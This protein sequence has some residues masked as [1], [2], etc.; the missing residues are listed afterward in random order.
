MCLGSILEPLFAIITGKTPA[1][2]VDSESSSLLAT[3]GQQPGYSAPISRTHLTVESQGNNPFE[4]SPTAGP[5]NGQPSIDQLRPFLVLTSL[6]DPTVNLHQRDPVTAMF[7]SPDRTTE[8][9]ELVANIGSY[10]LSFYRSST[11]SAHAFEVAFMII[12]K[13]VDFESLLPKAFTKA[14]ATVQIIVL[15]GKK[16]TD[17][18]T[19]CPQAVPANFCNGETPSLTHLLLR[20]CLLHPLS[21]L[22]RTVTHLRVEHG[23]DSP[24]AQTFIYTISSGANLR[25]LELFEAIPRGISKTV[26][27]IRLPRLQSLLIATKGGKADIESFKHFF[28]ILTAPR[29]IP[30]KV[31]CTEPGRQLGFADQ[32]RV[33][34]EAW[35]LS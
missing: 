3:H 30:I 34:M 14:N 18:K 12:D 32:V 7:P 17:S 8:L 24:Y 33:V 16:R 1:P 29:G 35:R 28:R 2:F 27:R 26:E 6:Y 13:P 15:T 22:G 19:T 25:H 4:A 11:H 23:A 10:S 20:H 5:P 31:V 21:T 9:T